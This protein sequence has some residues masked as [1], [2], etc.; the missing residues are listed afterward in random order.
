MANRKFAPGQ[1]MIELRNALHEVD[2]ENRIGKIRTLPPDITRDKLAQLSLI[3]TDPEVA[4]PKWQKQQTRQ[5]VSYTKDYQSI[6]IDPRALPPESNLEV[7]ISKGLRRWA[8]REDI[9]V[10]PDFKRQNLL[11]VAH[12]FHSCGQRTIATIGKAPEAE[13]FSVAVRQAEEILERLTSNGQ[14]RLFDI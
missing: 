10:H 6:S 4:L 1:K 3:D 2:E 5:Q 13:E 9:E 8:R 12:Q 14:R 7:E 11:K